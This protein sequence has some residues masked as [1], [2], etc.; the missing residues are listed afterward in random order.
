VASRLKKNGNLANGESVEAVEGFG[1]ASDLAVAALRLSRLPS[2]DYKAALAAEAERLSLSEAEAAELDVKA[3]QERQ[4]AVCRVKALRAK[5]VEAGCTEEEAGSAALKAEKLTADYCFDEAELAVTPDELVP[6]MEAAVGTELLALLEKIIRNYMAVP[7]HYALCA[8]LWIMYVHAFEAFDKTPY[9]V[10][11]SAA[12]DCGKSTFIELISEFVPR[13]HILGRAPPVALAKLIDEERP[14]L[15]LDEADRYILKENDYML[16]VLDVGHKRKACTI[17]TRGSVRGNRVECEYSVYCPKVIAFKREPSRKIPDVIQSRGIILHMLPATAN[18]AV[19]R[20]SSKHAKDLAPV[21]DEL[22]HW[23]AEVFTK[24]EASDPDMAG[25]INRRADNWRPLLSVADAIGGEVPSRARNALSLIQEQ[26]GCQDVGEHV[27]LLMGCRIVFDQSGKELLGSEEL[28]AG[29]CKLPE[30]EWAKHKETS[31]PI[32]R[33]KMAALLWEFHLRS[34]KQS[35]G[36]LRGKMRW[37]RS[38]FEPYW[39]AYASRV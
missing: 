7:E 28:I 21:R 10:L 2:S 25:L 15:F 33:E 6:D 34:R 38:P 26:T 17:R 18:D 29:L 1:K 35:S 9:L 27:R 24:L 30:S 5:T 39:K 13:P 20:F 36:Q 22:E 37:H 16:N 31:K 23:A 19:E 32:T 11:E 4:K 12:P 8:A 3:K 14:T